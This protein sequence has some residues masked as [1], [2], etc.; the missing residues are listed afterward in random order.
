MKHL[1]CS[2]YCMDNAVR[3]NVAMCGSMALLPMLY[4]MG[5]TFDYHAVWKN[6]KR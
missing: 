3:G 2:A 4:D 1:H 6:I 5:R